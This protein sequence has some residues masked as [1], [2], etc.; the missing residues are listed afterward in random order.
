MIVSNQILTARQYIEG[1]TNHY[2]L[3]CDTFKE[4]A[5][6][7]D[8]NGIKPKSYM[9]TAMPKMSSGTY[10]IVEFS[11]ETNYTEHEYR[12]MQIPAVLYDKFTAYLKEEDLV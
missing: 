2:Y 4:A 6:C 1:L 10:V 9:L 3:K 11:K 7:A 12:F 8:I 5:K